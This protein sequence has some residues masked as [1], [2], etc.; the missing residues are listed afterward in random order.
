MLGTC[1]ANCHWDL[2]VCR[3]ENYLWKLSVQIIFLPMGVFFEN[4]FLRTYFYSW[5]WQL[6]L[7]NPLGNSMASLWE[8]SLAKSLMALFWNY[9]WQLS[10]ITLFQ[11]YCWDFVRT[12]FED[13]NM[14]PKKNETRITNERNQI[15]GHEGGGGQCLVIIRNMMSHVT[16]CNAVYC[17]S[18]YNYNA[19]AAHWVVGR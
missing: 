12:L 19:K 6:S 4:S 9:L 5:H 11:D 1:F 18:V 15:P 2:S 8:L 16:T 10:L 7:R 3:P 17:I 13:C 14:H